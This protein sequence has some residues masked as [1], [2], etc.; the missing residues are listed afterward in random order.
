[1][2][3]KVINSVESSQEKTRDAKKIAEA[4]KKR[5]KLDKQGRYVEVPGY[6][7]KTEIFVKKGEKKESVINRFKNYERTHTR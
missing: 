6:R 1:M 7:P 4:K 2:E 5:E 3:K